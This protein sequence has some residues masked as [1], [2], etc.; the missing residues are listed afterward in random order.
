MTFA[1]LGL[2][3]LIGIALGFIFTL[4]VFSYILGDNPLF[5]FT[6]YLFIGISSGFIAIITIYNVLLPRLV[7]P[8]I[9]ANPSERLLGLIPLALS[10]LLLLKVS[11]RLARWGSPAMAYLVGVGAATAI[12][13]GMLGTLFPQVGASINLFDISAIQES[14]ANLIGQLVNGIV[15]LVGT[16][17][18]LAFFHFGARKS[19]DQAG[20]AQSWIDNMSQ[21]GRIF[22]AV[23]LGV[24]FAGVYSAALIAMVERLNFLVDFV[25]S[26]LTVFISM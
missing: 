6:V 8:L 25:R 24:L 18:S 1:E 11:P 4:L 17:T 12:G 16:V 15:I 9:Y 10:V 14:G 20:L 23:T 5:R 22:I 2:A 21:L 26:L 3:D 13:G 19:A 7:I